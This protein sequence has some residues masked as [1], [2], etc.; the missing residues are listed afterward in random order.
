MKIDRKLSVHFWFR[1]FII[2]KRPR[3]LHESHIDT[4]SEMKTEHWQYKM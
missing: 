3:D 2:A 1:S 4:H